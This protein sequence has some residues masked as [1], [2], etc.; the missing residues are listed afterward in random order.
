MSF[1]WAIRPALV[2]PEPSGPW[3]AAQF[4]VQLSLASARSCG[5]AQSISAAAGSVNF[6]MGLFSFDWENRGRLRRLG[7]FRPITSNSIAVPV[8]AIDAQRGPWVPRNFARYARGP[9]KYAKRPRVSCHRLTLSSHGP[10]PKILDCISLSDCGLCRPG[11]FVL[12][13]PGPARAR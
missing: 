13:G 5:T 3:H 7:L 12:P 4:A 2:C 10:E 6:F 9:T 11:V 1:T 8:M